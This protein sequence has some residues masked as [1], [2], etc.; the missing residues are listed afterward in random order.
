MTTKPSLGNRELP[1]KEVIDFLLNNGWEQIRKTKGSHEIWKS[2]SGQSMTLPMRR[3]GNLIGQPY[4]RQINNLT[5]GKLLS[6]ARRG[7]DQHGANLTKKH[8]NNGVIASVRAHMSGKRAILFGNSHKSDSIVVDRLNRELGLEVDFETCDKPRKISSAVERI[9]N[10]KYHFAMVQTRFLSHSIEELIIKGCRSAHVPYI[11][12]GK[13]RPLETAHA[14]S[15]FFSLDLENPPVL[16]VPKNM[17]KV[18]EKTLASIPAQ[19]TVKSPP[20]R[21]TE[22][23]KYAVLTSIDG[24]EEV[25]MIDV[26]KDLGIEIKRD[27]KGKVAWGKLS[28]WTSSIR[29]VLIELGYS[30]MRSITH[31]GSR[32]MVWT[33]NS[34]TRRTYKMSDYTRNMNK[35][36]TLSP[37]QVKLDVKDLENLEA[38][39]RKACENGDIFFTEDILKQLGVKVPYDDQGKINWYKVSHIT[40]AIGHTLRRLGFYSAQAMRDGKKK[41]VW[42]RQVTTTTSDLNPSEKPITYTQSQAQRREIYNDVRVRLLQVFE[43]YPDVS[44]H[45]VAKMINYH[46][47]SLSKIL[48]IESFNLNKVPFPTLQKIKSN[49]HRI[50]K[51][52]PSKAKIKATPAVLNAPAMIRPRRSTMGALQQEPERVPE[53]SFQTKAPVASGEMFSLYTGSGTGNL[54][55]PKSMTQEDIQSLFEQLNALKV[56]LDAKAK[57]G[58]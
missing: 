46:Q 55:V 20:Q 38:I 8:I 41:R 56:L 21:G 17:K 28:A 57:S 33:N 23:F 26:V 50:E 7:F 10:K 53:S 32:T 40:K 3:G 14:I 48:Q 44:R 18:V 39:L 47:S 2:P 4:L 6:R 15:K 13:A 9:N 11:R 5:Q 25:S 27:A 1:Y 42:K 43:E 30:N 51:R 22:E 16:E 12:V 29:K 36:K 31:T 49:M 45:K 35:S 58:S 52:F 34:K 37:I 19:N 24:L 54:S